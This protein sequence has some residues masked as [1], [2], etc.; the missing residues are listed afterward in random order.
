MYRI[1]RERTMR[2]HSCTPWTLENSPVMQSE[3]RI[4]EL[5]ARIVAER[6]S[7]KVAELLAELKTSLREYQRGTADMALRY[8][9]LFEDVA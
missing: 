4:Q 9:K 6:D 7:E 8:R 1:E 5:C 3:E 2:H